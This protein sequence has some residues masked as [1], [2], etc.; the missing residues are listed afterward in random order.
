M[1][2]EEQLQILRKLAS[3]EDNSDLEEREQEAIRF[4]LNRLDPLHGATLPDPE[5]LEGR[6]LA[7]AAMSCS[8]YGPNGKGHHNTLWDIIR[9]IIPDLPGD[10]EVDDLA[11]ATNPEAEGQR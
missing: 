7:K 8:L 3:G 2:R 1:S 5:S 11:R 4:A 6:I 10:I 9:D